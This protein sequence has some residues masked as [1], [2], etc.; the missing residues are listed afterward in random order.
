MT[1]LSPPPPY[2]AALVRLLQGVVYSEAADDWNV[3]LSHES[4]VR[5]YFA[6]IGLELRIDEQD[7]YAFL[8]YPSTGEDD[9]PT[10]SQPP[11]LIRRFPLSYDVTILCVLL[12]ERMLIFD[13]QERD[14]SRLVLERA[15]I[16]ELMK[17]FLPERSDEVKLE[18]RIDAAVRKAE[19]LG[20]LRVLQPSRNAF[21][22]R[23]ILK[24]R[25][26]A[27]TLADL[28]KNI[29]SY[30]GITTNNA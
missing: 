27:Q 24:A 2:S 7:G 23:R 6:K 22:V 10:V 16:H 15:E 28:K 1:V 13:A 17:P 3:I 12:R 20:F 30:V 18:S 11:R 19:E 25:M 4:P 9:S 14:S 21:E 29:E 26:D 8:A 5:D